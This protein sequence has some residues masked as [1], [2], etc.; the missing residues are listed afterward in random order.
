MSPV[1]AGD[2]RVVCSP[3]EVAQLADELNAVATDRFP[4][5]VWVAGNNTSPMHDAAV[6]LAFASIRFVR[7]MSL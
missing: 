2:V 7:L 5:A 1:V 6:G 4:V 3:D